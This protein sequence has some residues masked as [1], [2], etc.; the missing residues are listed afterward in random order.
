MRPAT[1]GSSGGSYPLGELNELE[2]RY[3]QTCGNVP[4]CCKPPT[5]NLFSLFFFF[6]L[7]ECLQQ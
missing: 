3:Q 1:G 7:F 5:L 6:V 4:N 2:K